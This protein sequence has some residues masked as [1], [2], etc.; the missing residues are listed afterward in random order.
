MILDTTFKPSTVF[1]PYKSVQND[2]DLIHVA[3]Q[4]NNISELEKIL[5]DKNTK[6]DA[7]NNNG[8]T[9][10]HIASNKGF[11]DIVEMLIN[12]GANIFIINKYGRTPY[13]CAE[14]CRQVE[15]QKIFK[16]AYPE[17][18]P[19]YS[20][21]RYLKQDDDYDGSKCLKK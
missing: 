13:K 16:D 12:Q 21:K 4:K 9:A 10:L 8:N 18:Y 3:A 5:K 6:I 11:V 19:E 15:V 7:T 17:Y 2:D 1:K 20:R 14:Y